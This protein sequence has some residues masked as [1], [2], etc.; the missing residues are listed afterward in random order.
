[1]VEERLGESTTEM[2]VTSTRVVTEV[3][4]EVSKVA[5]NSGQFHT[6]GTCSR[7][8]YCC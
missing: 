7:G 4:H 8:T 1:M 5:A 6:W 3:T 2:V